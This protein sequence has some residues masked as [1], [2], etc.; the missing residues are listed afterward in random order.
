MGRASFK[1]CL[2]DWILVLHLGAALLALALLLLPIEIK[3]VLATLSIVL[4]EV[5]L[6]LLFFDFVIFTCH[7]FLL[8]SVAVHELVLLAG[9]LAALLACI[10]GLCF[11][12][13]LMIILVFVLVLFAAYRRQFLQQMLHNALV[14]L[15]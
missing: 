7:V 9:S 5:V 12:L 13:G 3:F 4:H 15:F 14:H 1:F 8:R 2:A 10:V 6:A 11:A